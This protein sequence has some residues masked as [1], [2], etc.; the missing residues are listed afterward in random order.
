MS[1]PT[2][3][4]VD[5]AQKHSLEHWSSILGLPSDLLTEAAGRARSELSSEPLG[6]SVATGM[7]IRLDVSCM[8]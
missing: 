4:F 6:A 3:F 1:T 5:L 2:P 7:P 8:K